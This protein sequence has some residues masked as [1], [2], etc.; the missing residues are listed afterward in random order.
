MLRVACCLTTARTLSQRS[1][2]L[3]THFLKQIDDSCQL[4]R[5]QFVTLWLYSSR[6]A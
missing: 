5:Y 3:P 2:V 4:D 6:V 1:A